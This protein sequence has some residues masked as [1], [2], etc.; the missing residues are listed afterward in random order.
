[1]CALKV[2]QRDRVVPGR[3]GSTGL[4]KTRDYFQ[5]K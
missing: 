5:V 3:E 2:K 4:A 1:M